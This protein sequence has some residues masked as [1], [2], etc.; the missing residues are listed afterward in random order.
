LVNAATG[1]GFTEF[2]GGESRFGRR[3]QNLQILLVGGMNLG[4][5]P[6][7]ESGKDGTV[8]IKKRRLSLRLNL[9]I[10]KVKDTQ[11]C[12]VFVPSLEI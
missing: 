1:L 10:D 4:I 6:K 2:A 12:S 5:K 11:K 7:N 3:L 9:M 8:Q